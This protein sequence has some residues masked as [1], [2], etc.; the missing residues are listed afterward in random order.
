MAPKSEKGA[1][2]DKM[3]ARLHPHPSSVV[4]S[5]EPDP[6][7]GRK[8]RRSP[9]PFCL[10]ATAAKTTSGE[11]STFRGRRR[12]RSTSLIN[13]SR[14]TSRSVRDVSYSPSRKR[15]VVFAKLDRRRSQSPS[16]S[17]SPGSKQEAPRRR[18]HRTRSRSR[19]HH[20]GVFAA[21]DLK[22][23]LQ[24]EFVVADQKKAGGAAA[25]D[26]ADEG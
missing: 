22:S 10:V 16:R 25:V 26:K 5:P 12:Y 8:R 14:N 1:R 18:R 17:R 11:S 4:S 13:M 19:S 24:F 15:L 21:L 7:R 3:T 20:D 9:Q 2:G 6:Q 23:P